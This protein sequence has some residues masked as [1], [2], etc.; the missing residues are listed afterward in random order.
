MRIGVPLGIYAA[1]TFELERAERLPFLDIFSKVFMFAALAA[2]IFTFSGL[3][4]QL[5]AV[6]FSIFTQATGL[7]RQQRPVGIRVAKAS[8]TG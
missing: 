7:G 5:S 6:N 8:T 2:W 3:A 4:G 1:A